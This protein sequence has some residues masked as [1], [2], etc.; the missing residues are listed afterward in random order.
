MRGCQQPA[1][2]T[3]DG[4]KIS[5]NEITEVSFR[6][7]HAKSPKV[8]QK[9]SF[10]WGTAASSS[11]ERLC[12]VFK[13]KSRVIIKKSAPSPFG[14]QAWAEGQVALWELTLLQ[15]IEEE[16]AASCKMS[17]SWRFFERCGLKPSHQRNPA[18]WPGSWTWTGLSCHSQSR[19]GTS[20]RKWWSKEV[21][22]ART[23][24]HYKASQL[25]VH[26]DNDSTQC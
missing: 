13:K 14:A 8:R 12:T 17:E 5:V 24:F 3:T 15:H 7:T 10:R 21:R 11:A 19:W 18:S 4:A 25:F 1:R 22:P 2:L 16:R 26:P 20:Q 9:H 6:I 23:T